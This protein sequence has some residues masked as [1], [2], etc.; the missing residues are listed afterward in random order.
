MAKGAR[1]IE[2]LEAVA[3]QLDNMLEAQRDVSFSA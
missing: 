3:N 2:M 1:Q